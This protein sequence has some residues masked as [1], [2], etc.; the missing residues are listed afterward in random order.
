M[1]KPSTLHPQS[2]RLDLAPCANVVG[3]SGERPL[4]RW[5]GKQGVGTV[6]VHTPLSLTQALL[7]PTLYPQFW[8]VNLSV[9]LLRAQPA[10]P[11]THT[12]YELQWCNCKARLTKALWKGVRLRTMTTPSLLLLLLLLRNAMLTPAAAVLLENSLE[13]YHFS[14]ASAE[15]L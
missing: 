12:C 6:S 9:R 3:A 10:P 14:F 15:C 11:H 1:P 7:F 2:W 4:D 8:H 5:E 13:N